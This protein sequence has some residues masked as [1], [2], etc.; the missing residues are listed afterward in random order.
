MW[1]PQY[2]TYF[3]LGESWRLNVPDDYGFLDLVSRART[4]E[5]KALEKLLLIFEPAV[6]QAVA[7][8]LRRQ[9]VDR[10]IDPADVCQS[11]FSNFFLGLRNGKF[12]LNESDDTV[13]L[14]LVMGRNQV[15][16]E[17]R[18][19]RRQRRDTRRE[20]YGTAESFLE[21]LVDS[22][23][24]PSRIVGGQEILDELL[25]RLSPEERD[26]AEQRAAGRSWNEIAVGSGADALR[27]KLAR[28]IQRVTRELRIDSSGEARS[29]SAF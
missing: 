26:L 22:Q 28:A 19:L 14:L 3:P 15:K 16:S 7:Q 12:E 2:P 18:K 24:T 13:K 5:D 8:E 27:K 6:R 29:D 17:A 1:Q 9:Q 21:S 25:R 20:Q 10:R 23:G 4:G 11:V